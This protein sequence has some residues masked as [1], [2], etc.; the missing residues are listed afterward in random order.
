MT[1]GEDGLQGVP[2]GRLFG[3]VSL[4]S[5]VTLYYVV[6][7]IAALGFATIVRIVPHEESTL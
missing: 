4:E 7:V 3:L 2:R 6:L 5:D 1:G